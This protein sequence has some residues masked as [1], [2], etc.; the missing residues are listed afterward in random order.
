MS[1]N[2]FFPILALCMAL[3]FTAC[4]HRPRQLVV[5][6]SNDTH[7]QVEPCADGMGG[8]AA[9]KHFIDSVR[10]ACGNVLLLDAGDIFQGTPYFNM[11]DGRL[12][13]EAYNLM[14]YEAVTF[15]NHEF[16]KGIDTLAARVRQAQFPYICCNYDVSGT[17]LDGFTKPYVVFDKQGLRVGVLGLGVDPHGLILADNFGGIR[18]SDPIEAAN[19]YA[20]VLRHDEKCDFV[21]AL[22]HLGFAVAGSVSDSLVAVNST[23]IDLIVGGHTHGVRG[24]FAIPNRDGRTI[25]VMQT[26]KSGKEMDQVVV[27]Y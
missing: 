5:L 21:I 17:A 4:D 18:Y 12:E 3:G 1:K 24:V 2:K 11:F 15:G 25:T 16:D 8:Y 19:K 13:I 14:G 20:A 22:S 7:S 10:H 23:D 9:R 27:A 6:C 26:G